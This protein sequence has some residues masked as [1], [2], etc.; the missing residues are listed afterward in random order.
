VQRFFFQPRHRLLTKRDFGQVFGHCSVRVG[1]G[2]IL[3]LALPNELNHPR[4]GLVCRK[5]F[6]KSAAG[7][8]QFKRIARERFRLSQHDLPP[9]DIVILNR[10]GSDALNNDQLQKLFATAFDGLAKK[11]RRLGE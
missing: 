4:I 3:L 10:S 6:I 8:N 7:R 11:A 1:R 5:K 2:S 9:F